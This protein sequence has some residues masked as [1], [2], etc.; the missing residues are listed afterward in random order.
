MKKRNG[1]FFSPSCFHW[2]S[3]QRSIIDT[4]RSGPHWYR[5]S[6]CFPSIAMNAANSEIRRLA[7]IRQVVVMIS[8]AGC[9]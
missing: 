4:P 3:P 7:Y 9:S 5:F 2:R 6:H 1:H 8:F